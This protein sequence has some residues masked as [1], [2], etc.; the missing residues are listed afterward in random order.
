MAGR[1]KTVEQQELYMSERRNGTMQRRAAA[2]AGVS[3]RTGRRIENDSSWRAVGQRATRKGRTRVDPFVAVWDSELLPLL[4]SAPSLQAR[5]LLHD[6]QERYAGAYPDSLLRTLQR[7]VRQWRAVSGPD[8]T[9]CF[10]QQAIPGAQALCDFTLMDKLCVTIAGESFP[11]RLNHVRLRYSGFAYAEVVQG[12]ESFTALASGIRRALELFGGVPETMRTDSLRAAYKNLRNSD[13]AADPEQELTQ[14]YTDLCATYGMKPTRNNTGVSHENGGIESPHGHLKN[15]IDQ[16]LLLRGQRDF[17]S[18]EEY[19]TWIHA[20]MGKENG[21]RHDAI[22]IEVKKLRPLPPHAPAVFS[23]RSARV[24]G[25]GTITVNSCHYTVP[26]RLKGHQLSIQV[27]DAHIRCLL[28]SACVYEAERLR[29]GPGGTHTW[30]VNYRHVI[31]SLR[32][33]PGAFRHLRYRDYFHPSAVFKQAWDDL[34]RQLNP[35]KAVKVYLEIVYLAFQYSEAFV[36]DYLRAQHQQ[37]TLPCEKMLLQQLLADG[38]DDLSASLADVDV[39]V[40][41]HALDP[42]D[43]LITNRAHSTKAEALL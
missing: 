32:S 17:L 12:G 38:K 39:P 34:D 23:T 19:Q 41:Q 5:T 7:R 10:P 8:Q 30:S 24:S 11:H 36:S 43:E 15:R 27:F 35:D 18:V 31:T 6:L 33:K 26:S 13:K 16:E 28:G 21:R 40:E 29:T 1:S 42:Y 14:A 4:V 22:A 37:Q 20:L 2:V 9:L 25:N 3:E